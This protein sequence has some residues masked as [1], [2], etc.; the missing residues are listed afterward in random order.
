MVVYWELHNL[1]SS[2]DIIRMIKSRRM[3]WAG[4]VECI[5]AKV[6]VETLQ[7]KGPLG[8][9]RSRCEDNIKLDLRHMTG[10]YGLD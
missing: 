8:I 3:R 5:W 2:P 6:L 9:P 7:L 4:Q 1:N 10:M